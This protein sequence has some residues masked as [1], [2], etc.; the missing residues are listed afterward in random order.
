MA[1]QKAES[2]NP[3]VWVPSLYFTEA[4]PFVLVMSVSVMM[5]KYLNVSNADIAF[6]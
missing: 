1:I 2:R 3:W 6:F 5:Y 4:I